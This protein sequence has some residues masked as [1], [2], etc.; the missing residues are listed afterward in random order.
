[1][2]SIDIFNKVT[3][4][5]PK[6]E[7]LHFNFTAPYLGP[8]HLS[9]PHIYMNFLF[10]SGLCFS[11]YLLLR[12]TYGIFRRV[13]NYIKSRLYSPRYLNCHSTESSEF[14]RYYAVINGCANKVGSAFT[15][16]L[17]KQGFSLI[18]IDR[19]D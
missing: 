13:Y 18:L 2:E 14:P 11:S 3:L 8:V 10:Y 15:D 12:G 5:F 6:I 16:Y 7:P 9:I 1:M 17:F 4:S 19:A